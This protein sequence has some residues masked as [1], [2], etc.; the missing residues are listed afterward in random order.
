MLLHSIQAEKIKLSHS[1]VWLVLFIL[2]PIAVFLGTGN[3][4]MNR[5]M[6][7]KEWYSLW[8]QLLLFYGYF[9]CPIIIS[10]LCSYLFR[11]EN[12][13]HNW[14][15]LLTMPVSAPCT[16]FSKLISA[17][18]LAILAHCL[19]TIL[20]LVVGLFLHFK[21][22]IPKEFLN[23][24]LCGILSTI[25]ICTVQLTLSLIIRNFAVP[26]GLSLMLSLGSLGLFAKGYGI[27]SPYSGLVM[28]MGI[29]EQ[30]SLHGQE[31]IIFLLVN[32]GYILFFSLFSIWYLQKQEF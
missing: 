27:I 5:S 24:F 8:T 23:W 11:L 30:S 18:I 22:G 14:N 13:N 2:P 31:L 12:F 20:Y 9:I 28:G 21:T 7:T 4:W 19:I 25:A 26:I 17:S 3:Y 15:K 1:M 10:I 32:I 16:I 6:L 29:V